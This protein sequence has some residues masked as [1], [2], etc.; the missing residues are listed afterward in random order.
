M[1]KTYRARRRPQGEVQ[2]FGLAFLD[3]ISCGLGAVIVLL[4]IFSVMAE[5]GGSEVRIV[6]ASATR[7]S[8]QLPTSHFLVLQIDADLPAGMS[9][10]NDPIQ[11][12]EFR[13]VDDGYTGNKRITSRNGTK[14]FLVSL[15]PDSSGELRDTVILRLTLD[16][17]I[18]EM[19][20]ESAKEIR[21]FLNSLEESSLNSRTRDVFDN[22]AN[23]ITDGTASGRVLSDLAEQLRESGLGRLSRKATELQETFERVPVAGQISKLEITLITGK[24]RARLRRWGVSGDL[25]SLGSLRGTPRMVVQ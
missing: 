3:L 25:V 24:A 13:A 12:G 17:G 10:S 5:T 23:S 19:A 4:L 1:I 15:E 6:S 22:L 18:N 16:H 20:S 21:T 14:R 7:E 8:R 9:L 11:E 2:I